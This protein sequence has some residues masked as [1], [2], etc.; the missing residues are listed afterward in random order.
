MFIIIIE[1]RYNIIACEH[2]YVLRTMLLVITQTLLLVFHRVLR[3]LLYCYFTTYCIMHLHDPCID[4]RDTSDKFKYCH[5]NYVNPSNSEIN[6]LTTN[7]FLS[8]HIIVLLI[9]LF[10]P[11]ATHLTFHLITLLIMSWNPFNILKS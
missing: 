3:L 7:H 1:L 10:Q 6:P 11:F 8:C 2:N 5:T 4:F 9:F